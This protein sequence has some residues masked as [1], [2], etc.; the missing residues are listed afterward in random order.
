MMDGA[1]FSWVDV[2][3]PVITFVLVIVVPAVVA[4]WV[5]YRTVTEGQD[6]SPETSV[7]DEEAGEI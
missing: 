5:I 2:I 7:A 3:S 6:P 4:L 1:E